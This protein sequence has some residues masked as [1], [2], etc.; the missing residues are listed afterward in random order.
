[1]KR[2]PELSPLSHDHHKALAIALRLRRAEDAD[3]SKTASAFFEYWQGHG[4]DHFRIEEEILL[5]GWVDGDATADRTLA[6][7]VAD[8]HLEIRIAVRRLEGVDPSRD[9]LQELG[10][11]LERHV[12]FEERELFPQI[13]AGL[14]ARTIAALGERIECAERAG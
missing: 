9:E 13:E 3:A 1:M 14:D 7:R 12:R 5:P 2:S 11:L 10:G 6:G 8:E 4:A